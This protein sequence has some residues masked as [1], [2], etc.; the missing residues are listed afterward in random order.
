MRNAFKSAMWTLLWS[1]LAT[2]GL[3]ILGWLNDAAEWAADVADGGDQL[4]Q[5]PDFA[6]LTGT[7]MGAAFGV[8]GGVLVF[9]IRWGQNR[10]VLPGESP[11]FDTTAKP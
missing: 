1:T 6:V 5:F 2:S 11:H 9:F 7:L 4:V 10:N 3:A 8:A